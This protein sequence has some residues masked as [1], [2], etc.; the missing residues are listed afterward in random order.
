[1]EVAGPSAKVLFRVTDDDGETIAETLWA[2]P[3]GDDRYELA[4]SPFY[5]YGVS[6]KD[7]VLAPRAPDGMPEFQKILSKAGH[8]TVRVRLDPPYERGNV[9][10][11]RVDE[12]VALGC[13]FEGSHNTLISFDV[14]PEVK[15]GLVRD[16]LISIDAEWEHADPTYEE[17]FPGDGV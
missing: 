9:S 17:L 12:L 1:M 3:L 8:K 5:A 6:W 14:P 2:I 16:Y 15:L 4:N 7:V 13:S 10:A 11:K